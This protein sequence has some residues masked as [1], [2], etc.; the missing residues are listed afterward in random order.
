MEEKNSVIHHLKPL[1]GPHNFI[2]RNVEG[3]NSGLL[4]RGDSEKE[5]W[6]RN[7]HAHNKTQMLYL[8][9]STILRTSFYLD[10]NR[11]VEINWIH[12]WWNMSWTLNIYSLPSFSL[13]CNKLLRC[14][15]S[16]C[17]NSAVRSCE[18]MILERLLNA[19]C[20]SML[21]CKMPGLPAH[22]M[23]ELNVFYVHFTLATIF[24]IQ[25]KHRGW[26]T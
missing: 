10:V 25:N 6:W 19:C 22:L 2:P 24:K 12:F 16:T 21:S 18:A 5:W 11:K 4:P 14:G 23:S 15:A 7:V 20:S 1:T 3:V 26:N 9:E 17:R 13:F 8:Q